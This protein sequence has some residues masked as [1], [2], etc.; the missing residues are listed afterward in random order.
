ML[1]I[2]IL[3]SALD[4]SSAAP[5]PSFDPSPAG[6]VRQDD[7]SDDDSE[8]AEGSI[9]PDETDAIDVE[10]G[11]VDHGSRLPFAPVSIGLG[12]PL[13]S[14]TSH[15]RDA[16]FAVDLR[17]IEGIDTDR[18]RAS[19][20]ATYAYDERLTLGVEV[21]PK[22]DEFNP[23][24]I[25][26]VFDETREG[27]SLTI[28]TSTDRI[29]TPSGRS[30]WA[31]AG[32]SFEA[33]LDFPVSAYV[34]AAWGEFEDELTAIAGLRIDWNR[35]ISTTSAWDGENLNHSLDVEFEDGW[36]VSL[37]AIDDDLDNETRVGLSVGRAF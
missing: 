1:T 30:Y 26:R 33:A 34:G 32:R 21:A 35:G 7:P 22:D 13:R 4:A 23:L 5:G 28:G 20:T 14:A 6:T 17:L 31:T 11:P 15:Q 10:L 29:G 25:Y 27:P 9:E 12:A 2:A 18:S 8:A 37:L 16:R 24:V 3:L 19:L 36:R